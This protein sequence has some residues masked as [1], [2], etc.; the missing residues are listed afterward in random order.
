ML[1]VQVWEY[2]DQYSRKNPTFPDPGY[3]ENIMYSGTYD[4]NEF[5]FIWDKSGD[6][7]NNIHYTIIK[8]VN[9]IYLQINDDSSAGVSCEPESVYISC[10][11]HPHSALEF[12]DV[13][14]NGI[15]N[16]SVILLKRKE[17]LTRYAFEDMFLYKKK[18]SIF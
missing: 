5:N 18:R 12:Y 15:T 9:V 4:I 6:P 16:V 10:Q 3:Y 8:L 1:T 11:N 13:V 2:I 7:V 14:R 17:F